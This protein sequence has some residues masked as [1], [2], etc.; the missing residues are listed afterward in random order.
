MLN[1]DT[2]DSKLVFF[3]SKA[4]TINWLMGT[5]AGL[6]SVYFLTHVS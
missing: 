5:V 4:K 6:K 2:K 3:S 1:L